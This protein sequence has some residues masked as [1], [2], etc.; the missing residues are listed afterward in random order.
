[1]KL[2]EL[3]KLIR[4]EIKKEKLPI[5]KVIIAFTFPGNRLYSIDLLKGNDRVVKF[6]GSEAK[7]KT[8][9]WLASNKIVPP[10]TKPNELE[11][12]LTNIGI[13]VIETEMDVT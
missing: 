8:I 5:N 11:K 3:R 7:E 2:V 6:N 12:A 1:M 9:K 10:N 13:E 4:E